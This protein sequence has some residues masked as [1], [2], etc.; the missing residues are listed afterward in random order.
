MDFSSVQASLSKSA[1][2]LIASNQ[3]KWPEENYHGTVEV[4]N[5]GSKI[6]YWLFP[7]R[8]NPENA[9]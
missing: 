4:T 5:N 8:E 7:A 6:F 9:P 1:V 3:I 2:N